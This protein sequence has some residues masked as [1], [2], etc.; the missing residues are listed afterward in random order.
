[1]LLGPGG[2][3]GMVNIIPRNYRSEETHIGTEY[4]SNNTLRTQLS[5]GNT[6]DNCTYAVDLGHHHTDGHWSNSEEKMSN[7]YGR[8]SYRASDSL[9]LALNS[10]GIFGS[11][12]LRLAEPPAMG[13]LQ[14]R[15][16]SFDPMTTYML[17]GKINYVKD[18]SASTD[19]TLSYAAREFKG[20]RTG[21]RDW[22]EEDHEY[23]INAVQSLKLSGRN[24]LRIGGMYNFWKSPT[25][26][27]FYV[28]RPG[29]LWTYSWMIVDEHDFGRLAIDLGYRRSRT[30]YEQFGGFNVEGSAGKLQ[31]VLVEDEWEDPLNTV[32]LG[33]SYD[34]GKDLVIAG[35]T[36]WGQ[37]AASPG[38]L[39]INLAIPGAETRAKYDLGIRKRH[40]HFGEIA[41][42]GFYVKQV[43]AALVSNKIVTVN[44]EEYALYEGSDL[45]SS[46]LELEARSRRFDNGFQFFLNATAMKTRRRQ[47]GSWERDGEVPELVFGGGASYFH[48]DFELGLLATRLS[49]YE[50]ERFLPSGSAP[51][52]L[53]DFTKLSALLTYYFGP[54]KGREVFI[55]IDNLT[56]AAYS[57]VNG[58]PDEGRRYTIGCGHQF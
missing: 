53:G 14:T 38:M 15:K 55:K 4:G 2:M 26:K 24:I 7:I 25:G 54:G 50:N 22:W 45:D 18:L 42:T 10:F 39:D 33:L 11:R 5:H 30:Y 44:D 37:I 1:M 40:Q 28:G 57:T 20:H 36:T 16:E 23:G 52:P 47:V 13:T 58:Y 21:S 19:I 34:I 35:N 27:R 9:S 48:H 29:E 49:S 3:T 41:L 17:V 51:A 43:N 12:E 46:G 32:T 6:K 31:S 56:D 8:L